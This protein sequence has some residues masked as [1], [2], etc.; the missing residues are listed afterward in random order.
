MNTTF[1]Y[2]KQPSE[3]AHLKEYCTIWLPELQPAS[4]DIWN[5]NQ[6]IATCDLSY[7]FQVAEMIQIGTITPNEVI[8]IEIKNKTATGHIFGSTGKIVNFF[9][10]I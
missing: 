9:R 1:Y 8:W 7:L 3:M 10:V 2:A 4:P 5:P 6:I